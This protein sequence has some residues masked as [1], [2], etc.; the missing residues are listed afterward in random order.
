MTK[1]YF[2]AILT[3]ALCFN[4]VS[5]QSEYNVIDG[6]NSFMRLND[7]ADDFVSVDM[8]TTDGYTFYHSYWD[9][10]CP[11]SVVSEDG[12]DIY[13]RLDMSNVTESGALMLVTPTVQLSAS[14]LYDFSQAIVAAFNVVDDASAVTGLSLRLIKGNASTFD[15]DTLASYSKLKSL[16]CITGNELSLD[17]S[18]ISV[19]EDGEYYFVIDVTAYGVYPGNTGGMSLE[20]RQNLITDADYVASIEA[21]VNPIAIYP[22]PTSETL[23]ILNANGAV[24]VYDITGKV[25]LNY[26]NYSGETLDVSSLSKGLYLVAVDGE[27]HRFI[28]E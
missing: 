27:F 16:T 12:V 18:D 25:V 23:N 11:W 15:V 6:P 2:L 9:Y 10:E 19:T 3:I 8:G 4:L 20:F 7:A 17:A 26:S 1:K 22:N 14:K 24:Q 21:P 13:T 28:K 5:A